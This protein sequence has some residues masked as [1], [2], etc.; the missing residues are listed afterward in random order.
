MTSQPS[1]TAQA[2]TPT[3]RRARPHGKE[4]VGRDR[5]LAAAAQLF[6]EHGYAATTT[7]QISSSVGIKQPSLYYHFPN[8]ASML[9]ELLVATAEPSVTVARE[10][11]ESPEGTALD[12]LLALIRFDVELLASGEWNIG[13]LY[14]LPE[15]SSPECAQFRRL[16]DELKQ[17]YAELVR[18]AVSAGLAH[19]PDTQR[20]AA[21]IF[22]LVEGVILRR[23]D[24]KKLDATQTAQDIES[25]TLLLLGASRP[26]PKA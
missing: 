25:A 19:T 13:S 22:S 9:V 26:A 14:L 8:K 18:G 11:L 4:P 7:R 12:K 3:A 17:A 24:D 1:T 2:P 20:A 23:N 21:L 5:I 10:L 6:V 16:R 15:T